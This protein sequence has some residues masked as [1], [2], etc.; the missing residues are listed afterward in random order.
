M[1]TRVLAEHTG[2]WT[3]DDVEA[4]PDAGDHARFEVYEGGVL[5]VTP[6]PGEAHQRTSYWLRQALAQ[7]AASARADVEVLEAVNVALPGSKLLVPDVVVV[8]RERLGGGAPPGVSGLLAGHDQNV[9]V[10]VGARGAASQRT[11]QQQPAH[12]RVRSRIGQD[13][14]KNTPVQGRRVLNARHGS[15]R[16]PV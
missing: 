10:G 9:D 15:H 7:A 4:L 16:N 3:P 6:A 1:P 14:R 11:V 13:R 5:V 2:P 12:A 8:D